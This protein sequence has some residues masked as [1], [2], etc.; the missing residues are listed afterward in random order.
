MKLVIYHIP[1]IYIHIYIGI[2]HIY[3]SY[4]IYIYIVIIIFFAIIIGEQIC[5]F[6]IKNAIT[7][8]VIVVRK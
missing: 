4:Y 6:N 1:Y 2:S 5:T 3:I 8:G 7:P